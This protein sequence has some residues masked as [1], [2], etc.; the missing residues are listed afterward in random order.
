M[1]IVFANICK[2]C[3]AI[4]TR[5]GTEPKP[6]GIGKVMDKQIVQIALQIVQV[7]VEFVEIYIVYHKQRK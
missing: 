2:Y 6:K 5:A 3:Y 4:P 7:V 1:K